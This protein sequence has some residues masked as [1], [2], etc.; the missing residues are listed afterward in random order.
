MGQSITAWPRKTGFTAAVV[1]II[2]TITVE[3]PV[4]GIPLALGGATYAAI[5]LRKPDA[6][7]RGRILSIREHKRAAVIGGCVMLAIAALFSRMFLVLNAANTLE[8]DLNEAL[9]ASHRNGELRPG[10][11]FQACSIACAR[12]TV[13]NLPTRN[14]PGIAKLRGLAVHDQTIYEWRTSS[15]QSD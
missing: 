14:E 9:K 13:V 15:G 7:L 11:V 10:Q 6:V 12:A 4:F 8:R 1:A 5:R 3:F 2:G